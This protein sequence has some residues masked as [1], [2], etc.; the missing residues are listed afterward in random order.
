MRRIRLS[1]PLL[2]NLGAAAVAALVVV[3]SVPALVG[4]IFAPGLAEDETQERITKLLAAHD[5]DRSTYVGRFDGRSLFVK[6]SPPPPVREMVRP[7]EPIE[8]PA[9][10][11]VAPT[12]PV[13][14]GGP[15]ILFV[16]G[17]EVW[18]H[19]GMTLRVGEEDQGVKVIAS[20][21][22]WSVRLGHGGGEYDVPLFQK[23][24]PGLLDSPPRAQR[25]TPGLVV[26]K[27]TEQEDPTND[28]QQ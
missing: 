21:A 12:V 25:A 8:R 13:S 14:Y 23:A 27:S 4:A 11:P 1:T 18:F 22:P 5:Q 7:Q 19:N 10:E 24:F 3:A 20:N 17:D 15:S 16:L 9:P 2:V 6:P 28:R 26:V